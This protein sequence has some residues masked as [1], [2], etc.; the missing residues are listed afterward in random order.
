MLASGLVPMQ[1]GDTCSPVRPSGLRSAALTST[2]GP[3][4]AVEVLER[5]LVPPFEGHALATEGVGVRGEAADVAPAFAVG[6][7]GQCQLV[8]ARRA[9]R[10]DHL[11]SARNARALSRK[12]R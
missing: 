2:R 6:Q 5:E 4:D 9:Q 3:A 12:I 10:L 7:R 1:T 11:G 8:Y